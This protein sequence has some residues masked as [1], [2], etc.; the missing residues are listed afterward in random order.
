MRAFI[1]PP[2]K[3]KILPA[4]QAAAN[5]G[6]SD[7]QTIDTLRER[8][9]LRDYELGVLKD[10][11]REAISPMRTVVDRWHNDQG[12]IGLDAI[13]RCKLAILKAE[14]ALK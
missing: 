10:A 7:Q 12:I 2:G 11:L 1:K 6:N 13:D 3:D 9:L 14:K 4:V 5:A 8:L